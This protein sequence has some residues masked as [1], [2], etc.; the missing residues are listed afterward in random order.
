MAG[1]LAEQPRGKRPPFKLAYLQGIIRACGGDEAELARWTK[2]W[3][4]VQTKPSHRPV[5]GGEVVPLNR[6]G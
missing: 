1:L 4:L 6:A 5:A 3:R 2:A